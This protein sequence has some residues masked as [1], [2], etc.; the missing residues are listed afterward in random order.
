VGRKK[1]QEDAER[2]HLERLA[3]EK[4]AAAFRQVFSSVMEE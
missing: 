3:E 2:Q 1:E 4:E